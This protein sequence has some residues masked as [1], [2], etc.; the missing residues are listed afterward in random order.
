MSALFRERKQVLE[1][2]G[3][4]C[5]QCGTPQYPSNR[6][7]VNPD[8]LAIDEMEDYRFADRKAVVFSYTCDNLAASISPPAIYGLV[9]FEG[10]GRYWFDFADCDADA[11]RVG[12]P[13]RMSFRR[14]YSDEMR[15]IHAYF[16]KAA[17]A[18]A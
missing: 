8:C 17:P 4:R 2:C 13:V 5:R 3:S 9:D 7:C 18:T 1:L 12:M 6:I 16:W 10:G 15:G 14:K 11:V